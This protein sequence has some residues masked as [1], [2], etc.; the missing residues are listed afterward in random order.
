VTI[1]NGFAE[2][3]AAS[4]HSADNP[5]TAGLLTQ[6]STGKCGVHPTCAGQSLLTQAVEKAIKL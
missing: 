4:L 5:C 3:K 6:L 1:A 2:Y